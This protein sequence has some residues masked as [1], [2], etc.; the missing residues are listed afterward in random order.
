[1]RL[2]IR[3]AAAI[4][5]VIHWV[6]ATPTY[7][8]FVGLDATSDLVCDSSDMVFIAGSA[9]VGMTRSIDVFFNLEEHGVVGFY[10]TFCVTDKA[11]IGQ[12]LWTYSDLP[13]WLAPRPAVA[14]DTSSSFPVV[15][16]EFI[17]DTYPDYKCWFVCPGFLE[18][19][20]PLS[21]RWPPWPPVY[22]YRFGTLQY[23][24]AEEGC[25]QWVV[26][27]SNTAYLTWSGWTS[28][29]FDEPGETCDTTSCSGV[30]GTGQAS[31]GGV[32]S[33]FR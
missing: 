29:Y 4:V 32:K 14:S 3:I 8:D 22:P 18:Q 33:L 5:F 10:C 23:E 12:A 1:M 17:T 30:T 27:G 6:G 20:V 19:G 28:R 16:S 9:D 31:W 2:P 15:V 7:A 25:L 13:D 11:H 21:G 26:D 24:V